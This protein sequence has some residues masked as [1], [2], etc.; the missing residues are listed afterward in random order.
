[1]RGATKNWSE[2]LSETAFLLTRPMRGATTANIMIDERSSISTHTPHAGRDRT[3]HLFLLSNNISTH[4]PH[5]GRDRVFCIIKLL[6]KHFYS[7]A[8]C[9]ARQC[10]ARQHFLV[11]EFLLTRPMRGAT[12]NIFYFYRKLYFLLTRPMRGATY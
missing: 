11:I 7:H 2:T 6:L 1:M 5:A 4:T 9:G 8:P 3:R 12:L 10:I